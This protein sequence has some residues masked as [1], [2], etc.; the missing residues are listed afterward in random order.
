M[1]KKRSFIP[2]DQPCRRGR[3]PK[4]GRP[5]R[6]VAVTLP[7]DVV[8][9]LA[10]VDPDVGR[11][12]VR[13]HD[14][15]VARRGPRERDQAVLRPELV[16]VGDGRA[17]IVV[18]PDLVQGLNGVAAIPFGE[19]RA[20]LALEPSWTMADLELSVVDALDHGIADTKRRVALTEFRD[21]L[22]TWRTDRS[23]AFD[24]RTIIVASRGQKGKPA[25]A[26]RAA[27]S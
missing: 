25:D 9:W 2:P 6:L 14:L 11:A 23:T 10:S 26:T 21:Q 17:L 4:Y 1:Q 3:P 8:D 16:D 22:R 12:V 19:A 24:T 15:M 13:L 18:N 7:N 20:F 27:R 5:A